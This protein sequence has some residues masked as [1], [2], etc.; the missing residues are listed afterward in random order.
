MPKPFSIL[1]VGC[2]NMGGA[3]LERWAVFSD[4]QGATTIDDDTYPP[5]PIVAISRQPKIIP[6]VQWLAADSSHTDIGRLFPN[7]TP[8]IILLA[9]KPQD[10]AAIVPRYQQYQ[11]SIFI[12]IMAGKGLAEL[13]TLL[14]KDKKI[15][16]AMPN[17]LVKIGQGFT[18][19]CA[20]P[21][22]ETEIMQKIT[23]LF[24]S[25]G[26][27]WQLDNEHLFDDLTA[28]FGCAPGF[29]FYM[30]K[31]MATVAAEKVN[32]QTDDEQHR[33]QQSLLGMMAG[34]LH[35]AAQ[36]PDWQKLYQSVA[37]RGGMTEAGLN[38]LMGHR[39][40]PNDSTTKANHDFQTLWVDAMA[41][42][43]NRAKRL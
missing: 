15:I 10:A 35:L 43:T 42:A 9:V 36:E 5:S 17:M 18:T 20:A 31:A 1:S 2:G 24:S 13:A 38:I 29:V 33:L 28:L 30:L 32:P 22:V 14:G 23:P 3:L 21:T 41:A 37:S 6:G 7:A 27:V 40:Q 4:K 8:D 26:I 11:R 16:R 12:S 39:H 34:C 25:C 19:I